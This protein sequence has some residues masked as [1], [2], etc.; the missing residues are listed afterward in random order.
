MELFGITQ[1]P[2]VINIEYYDKPD[3]YDVRNRLQISE[4]I[5]DYT[6]HVFVVK[7][8]KNIVIESVNIW[9]KEWKTIEGPYEYVKSILAASGHVIS[10][11]ISM[12][13]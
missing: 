1:K 7:R 9:R 2:Y 3:S 12:E 4:D 13:N 5:D 10:I 8:Q 6:W 11:E